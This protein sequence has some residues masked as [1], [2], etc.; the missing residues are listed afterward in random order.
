MFLKQCFWSHVVAIGS[1]AILFAACGDDS[2]SSMGPEKGTEFAETSCSS[3]VVSS[4]SEKIIS[5]SSASKSKSS[6]SVSKI[7]SS[8]SVKL[9]SSSSKAKSSSNSE[10]KQQS[11]AIIED[12]FVSGVSQKGPFEIGSAVKLYELDNKTFAQTGKSFTGQIA[13]ND[14]KFSVTSVTLASEY[15]L[16]LRSTDISVTN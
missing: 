11:S 12:K 7:V 4:S 3:K 6:S 10:V 15:M 9:T 16:Y 2:S 13:S 8:S 1:I 14:G 5:L